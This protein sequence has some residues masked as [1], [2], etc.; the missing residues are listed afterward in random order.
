MFLALTHAQ[1]TLKSTGVNQGYHKTGRFTA[2][3]WPPSPLKIYWTFGA[4]LLPY[5]TF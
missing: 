3:V 2:A 5:F 4:T 1:L